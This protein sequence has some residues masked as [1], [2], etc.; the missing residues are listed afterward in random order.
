MR[1]RGD[2]PARLA[3]DVCQRCGAPP[4]CLLD[5]EGWL[6]RELGVALVVREARYCVPGC[7]GFSRLSPDPRARGG[8]LLPAGTP[9]ASFWALHEAGHLLM[10]TDGFSLATPTWQMLPEER[11]ADLF[12]AC[13]LIDG[14]ELLE[15]LLM[16]ASLEDAASAWDV[17]YRAV[18]KRLTVA[19]RMGEITDAQYRRHIDRVI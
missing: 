10:G 13:A 4:A 16:G 14:P 19:C 5:L 6:D 17:P 8:I 2:Y 1:D 12:A 9:H 18:T 3:R 7:R 15:Y 11:A